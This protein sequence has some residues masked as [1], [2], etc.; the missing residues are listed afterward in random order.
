MND[1]LAAF[2]FTLLIEVPIWLW[3]MREK[4]AGI[5]WLVAIGASTVTHPCLWF[6]FPWETGNYLT[7]LIIA[8]TAVFVVEG[9][10]A[11]VFKVKRPF[12]LAFCANAVSCTAG[13]IGSAL[14]FR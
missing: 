6:L 3:W 11:M 14:L 13:L 9:I 7:L 5:R 8:E 12:L 4:P 2:F 10:W 1:W